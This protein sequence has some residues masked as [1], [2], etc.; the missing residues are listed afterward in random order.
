[1]QPVPGRAPCARQGS[2]HGGT[3]GTGQVELPCSQS[4]PS[5]LGETDIEKNS[6]ETLMPSFHEFLKKEQR[7]EGL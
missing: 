1:M 5:D 7:A 2:G 3:P 6:H 4:L